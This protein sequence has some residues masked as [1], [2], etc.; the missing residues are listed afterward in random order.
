MKAPVECDAALRE[1]DS[2]PNARHRRDAVSRH[3]EAVSD[4]CAQLLVEQE[5]PRRQGAV[6][7]QFGH[8]QR[9]V[10]PLPEIGDAVSSLGIVDR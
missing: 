5:F 7:A 6:S 3:T 4:R 2:M 9:H 10:I 8:R 1:A